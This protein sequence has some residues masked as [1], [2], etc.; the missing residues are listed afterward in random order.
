[1]QDLRLHSFNTNHL[2][3]RPRGKR[4]REVR[5]ESAL[6]HF[7]GVV[8]VWYIFRSFKPLGGVQYR[9]IGSRNIRSC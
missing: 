3:R 4:M 1:M 5:R 2:W 8:G 9:N 7:E 6:G